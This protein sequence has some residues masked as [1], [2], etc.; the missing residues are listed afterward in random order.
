MKKFVLIL[1]LAIVTTAYAGNPPWSDKKADQ[2]FIYGVGMAMKQKAPKDVYKRTG[3]KYMNDYV[4]EAKDKALKDLVKKISGS[5]TIDSP[6]LTG[7][8][9]YKDSET[10]TEYWYSYR[11]PRKVAEEIAKKMKFDR[12]KDDMD[13]GKKDFEKIFDKEFEN[14]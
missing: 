2:F 8:S 12:A 14:K 3:K 9:T 1:G 13:K 5:M 10:S 11:M 4:Q 7:Y 6:Y